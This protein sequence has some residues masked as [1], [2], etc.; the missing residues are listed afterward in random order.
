M[1]DFTLGIHAL[2]CRN[3]IL[4]SRVCEVVGSFVNYYQLLPSF[5]DFTRHCMPNGA[6]Q[7]IGNLGSKPK[8]PTKIKTLCRDLPPF[9]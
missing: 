7:A 9:E 2:P 1:G 6:S 4:A 8:K 3:K 5:L